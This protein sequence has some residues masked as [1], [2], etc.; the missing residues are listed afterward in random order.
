M[1]K[2]FT[3][4]TDTNI[5]ADAL[6]LLA[7]HADVVH[8]LGG[9]ERINGI[10]ARGLRVTREII[11]N[12]PNLKV[13]ARHGVGVDSVDLQAAR[14]CGVT[15]INTPTTNAIS[16][17]EYTVAQFLNLQRRLRDA[18]EAVRRGTVKGAASMDLLGHEL[19]GKT[20]GQIGMGNI[21]QRI[22]AI[23]KNGFQAKV[24]GYDPFIDAE[25]AR[26]RGFEPAA[27]LEEL[28]ERSDLININVPLTAATRDMISG[29]MFDHFKAGAVL[30]N[31]AR[32]GVVNEE[33]LYKALKAGKLR[34]AAIDTFV[35]EPPDPAD[36]L[37][38]LPNLYAS[39][40]IGGNTREALQ[41]TGREVVEETLRVL[42]G[43]TPKHKVI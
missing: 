10:I 8:D 34:A 30:V 9:L 18:D 1:N 42:S 31:A 11:E 20:F 5:D 7:Q 27:S 22:A 40:H 2:R 32:G 16:V 36:K 21:A 25:E 14:E 43:E 3:V 17:A 37:L 19:Y 41:R 35:K 4:Y 23:M 28:L 29:G 12:A 33:D 38:S 26:K 39:P 15:V 6:A 24:L 13:I